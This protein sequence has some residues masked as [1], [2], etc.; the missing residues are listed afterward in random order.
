MFPGCAP[1]ASTLIQIFTEQW[2][3]IV[4][5]PASPNAGNASGTFCH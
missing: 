2:A 3:G 4:I 1:R 5:S